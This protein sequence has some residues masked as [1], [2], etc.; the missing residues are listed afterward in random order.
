MVS[1]ISGS[2]VNIGCPIPLLLAGG[3]RARHV[4]GRYAHFVDI[5]SE[6]VHRGIRERAATIV[7][8]HG[9]IPLALWTPDVAA[10]TGLVLVGHGGSGHKRQDYVVAL[11]KRLV[12]TSGA[13]VA[14]I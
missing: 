13:A 8:N 1:A 2:Y 12:H 11:A 3:S 5:T 14:C 6:S 7:G 9:E 10:P 4:V